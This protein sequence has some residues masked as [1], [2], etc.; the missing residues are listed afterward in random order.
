MR[1]TGEKAAVRYWTAALLLLIGSVLPLRLPHGR[2]EIPKHVETLLAET[3]T[4]ETDP[5]RIAFVR[6][7]CGLTGRV[8][9]FW[10]G[11][12][13]VLG[14]DRRWGRLRRVTSPGSDST[15]RLLPYGLDCSGLVSWAAAM[16]QD[17]PAAYDQVGEGVKAQYTLCAPVETPRPGDLAFFPDLSHVG[18]ILGRDGE[19]VLW[20]VHCSASLGGVV[21]TPVS[22]GF[23]LYGCPSFFAAGA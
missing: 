4:E 21:V 18:I 6:A 22:V 20:A 2:S 11:K 13:H 7:A 15:G 12:S 16:A 19:G 23:T 8:N 5:G 1:K 3:L 9:Y 10:G 17:D 14:W